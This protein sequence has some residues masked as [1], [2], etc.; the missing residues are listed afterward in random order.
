MVI[1]MKNNIEP[2]L[3]NFLQFNSININRKFLL[4]TLFLIWFIGAPCALLGAMKE[5]TTV[6]FGMFN[7]L[8]TILIIWKMIS[9]PKSIITKN[10][11]YG[12]IVIYYSLIFLFVAYKFATI[13]RDSIPLFI[14]MLI[15]LIIVAWLYIVMVKYNIKKNKYNNQKH[16]NGNMFALGAIGGVAGMSVGGLF[17]AGMSQDAMLILVVVLSY[18]LSLLLNSGVT[19]VYKA[20]IQRKVGYEEE[21]K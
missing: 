11:I 14:I 7:I 19:L 16:P 5:F 1:M 15:I 21:I 6:F 10:L 12:L 9:L 4:S 17:L 3:K 2:N 18:V 8:F 13:E 20:Y